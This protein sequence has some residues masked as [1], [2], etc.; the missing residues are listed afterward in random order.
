MTIVL[1]YLLNDLGKIELTPRVHIC[2][3]FEDGVRVQ[4]TLTSLGFKCDLLTLKEDK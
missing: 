3:S 4:N 1:Y 2:K